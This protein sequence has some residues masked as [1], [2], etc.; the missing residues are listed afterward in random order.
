MSDDETRSRR[1]VL[2]AVGVAVA[3]T[4]TALGRPLT[5]AAAN[6]APTLLGKTNNATASTVISTT[7]GSG[8]YGKSS[9]TLGRGLFGLA[10]ATTG[11]AYGVYGT[12]ASKDGGGVRGSATATTSTPNGVY[13]TTA[14]PSGSGVRGKNTAATGAGPGVYGESLASPDGQGVQ[15]KG[16]RTGV[17][18]YALATTG[19]TYGVYGQ[20]LNYGGYALY[21]YGNG[22]V[23]GGFSKAG[24]AFRIDH[25][26][27]PAHKYLC[28]S[29][30]E[31]PDMKNVYDGVVM[32][33]GAGEAVVELPAW[34]GALNRDVRYQLTAIGEFAPVYVKTEFADNRFMIA[35]GPAGLKVSWQL[36]GIRRDAWANAHRIK[37][38][39]S[40]PAAEQGRYLHP[41]E[42]GQPEALAIP[43]PV[44]AAAPKEE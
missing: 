15:G 32:L 40:K 37:V 35:G 28:H 2:A 5:A 12:C 13:G 16:N 21:G 27:D 7:A 30:V 43:H 18:G 24:G 31:S 26:L 29:F 14:A 10:T 44:A 3:G 6:G 1:S 33:D 11:A 23:T 4:A 8:L 20:N 22:A 25:P 41:A 38:E 19:L 34:F 36:T 42:H 17:S 9:S 39:V